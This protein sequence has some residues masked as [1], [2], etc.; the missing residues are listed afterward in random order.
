[1][2]L[3]IYIYQIYNMKKNNIYIYNLIYISQKKNNI[4]Y[5][6]YVL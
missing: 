6:I 1:M 4:S 3:Y 2:Y 5:I